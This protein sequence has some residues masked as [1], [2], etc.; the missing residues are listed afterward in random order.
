MPRLFLMHSVSVSTPTV[1]STCRPGRRATTCLYGG[2]T[3][4]HQLLQ[5]RIL[6][7]VEV[8]PQVRVIAR[9]LCPCP[10]AGPCEPPQPALL[11]PGPRF[12]CSFGRL[13]SLFSLHL[14]T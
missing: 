12:G 2:I 7:L 13:G 4:I 11:L 3:L 6:L 9:W 5:F 1:H 8:P 10:S 14:P